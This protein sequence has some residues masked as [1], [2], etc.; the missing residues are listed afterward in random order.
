[1]KVI[2][3]SLALLLCLCSVGS[4]YDGEVVVLESGEVVELHH[5]VGDTYFIR[6]INE[7]QVQRAADLLRSTPKQH[8]TGQGM[9]AGEVK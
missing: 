8:T 4:R 3:A 6:R 7:A 5:N 2:I 9:P 1:M